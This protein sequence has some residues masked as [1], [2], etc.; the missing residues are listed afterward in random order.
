MIIIGM[1]VHTM[2]WMDSIYLQDSFIYPTLCNLHITNYKHM[3][4]SS[5]VRSHEMC[6]CMCT[7]VK[8]NMRRDVVPLM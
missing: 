7:R 6:V 2:E 5:N 4:K 3:L 1:S 8:E